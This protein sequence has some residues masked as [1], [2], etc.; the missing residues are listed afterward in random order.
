MA[1]ARTVSDEELCVVVKDATNVSDVIRRLGKSISGSSHRHWSQ[2]ISKAGIDINHFQKGV[3][4]YGNKSDSR[5]KIP[6]E[7]LVLLPE[8]SRRTSVYSIR[9]ALIESGVEHKCFKCSLPPV[10]KKRLLVLQVDHINGVGTDNRIENLRFLCPNCH[11]QT[12]TYAAKKN[13]KT[14]V[15]R[16]LFGEIIHEKTNCSKCGR[17][18]NSG[19]P[20]GLCRNCI[21]TQMAKP[22]IVWPS[23]EELVERLSR[24]TYTGVADELGVTD[25]AIRKYLKSRVEGLVASSAPPR[26]RIGP[27]DKPT[28]SGCGKIVRKDSKTGLCGTCY[29]GPKTIDWP[30]DIE[31]SK[32]IEELG[33]AGTGKKLDVSRG[34]VHA[35]YRRRIKK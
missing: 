35:R 32:M 23:V 9:R 16:G 30:T 31:L 7:I 28:C 3:P 19:T 33:F 29:F 15:K 14:T 22:K 6:T 12:D 18:I 34:Q 10:W 2:R 17:K 5:K 21:A 27:E 13:I 25:N 11:S 8:G 1:R 26:P 20:L 4:R 24:G